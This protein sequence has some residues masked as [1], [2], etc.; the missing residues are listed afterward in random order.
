MYRDRHY[1]EGGIRFFTFVA[2]FFVPYCI[3]ETPARVLAQRARPHIWLSLAVLLFGLATVLFGTVQS[4]GGLLAARVLGGVSELA[5]L[6]GIYH[7]TGL[8]YPRYEAVYHHDNFGVFLAVVA[9]LHALLLLGIEKTMGGVGG[10]AG[11]RWA[12]LLQGALAAVFGVLVFFLLPGRPEA[13]AWLSEGDK[14]FVAGR[15]SYDPSRCIRMPDMTRSDIARAFKSPRLV[16]GSVIYCCLVASAYLY[17]GISPA[18]S[19]DSG[20]YKVLAQIHDNPW[21]VPIVFGVLIG[22]F[23]GFNSWH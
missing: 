20:Y 8:W 19:R 4:Y 22:P 11:W 3:L 12:F 21:V 18:A 1:A 23:S 14:A 17:A 15:R 13:S 7:V 16:L 10:Y 9:A 6:A 2:V 5:M